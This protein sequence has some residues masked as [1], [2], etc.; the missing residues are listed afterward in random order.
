MTIIQILQIIGLVIGALAGLAG[1]AALLGVAWSQFNKGN[2]TEK[3]EVVNSAD[4]I[5]DF[6]KKQADDYKEMMKVKDD[7]NSTLINELTRKVGELTGQLTAEKAQNERYEKIFQGRNPEM[8]TFMKF[9]IQASKDQSESTR[10][11]VRVLGE[12][13]SM[14]SSTHEIVDAR[15]LPVKIEGTIQSNTPPLNN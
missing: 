14:A 7:K 15:K 13:H 12:I 3:N 1:V 10:E 2:R 5:A 6:W 9:M 11:I 8:D 4:T